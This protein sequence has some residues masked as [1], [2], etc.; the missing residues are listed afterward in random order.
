MEVFVLIDENA[1]LEGFDNGPESVGTSLEG[2]FDSFEK[3]KQH[4]EAD[5]DMPQLEIEEEVKGSLW[6]LSDDMA[7]CVY[8][9]KKEKVK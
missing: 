5:E 6:I 4:L 7:Y 3:A 9:I 2:V 8:S 1:R